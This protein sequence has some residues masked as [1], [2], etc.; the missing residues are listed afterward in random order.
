[1][2]ISVESKEQSDVIT[3]SGRVDSSASPELDAT[4]KKHAEASKHILIELSGV[5]FMSSAGIRALVSSLRATA[6][7]SKKTVLVNPSPR[8]Q[9]VLDLSGL[10]SIFSVYDTVDIADAIVTT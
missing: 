1:M 4:L 8:V 6:A 5:D 3:V 9:E 2:N 7:N 10:N